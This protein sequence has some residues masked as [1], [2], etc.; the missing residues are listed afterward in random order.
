[1]NQNKIIL[2]VDDDQEV[3]RT[4]VRALSSSPFQVLEASDF[5]NSEAK[6]QFNAPGLI[7]C[8]SLTIAY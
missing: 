3:R 6:Y 2:L 8:N 1:M 4:I 7:R 5:A